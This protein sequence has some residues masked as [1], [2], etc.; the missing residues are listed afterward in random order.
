M[1]RATI[2][3]SLNFLSAS[4]SMSRPP[5]CSATSR[6]RYTLSSSLASGAQRMCVP[7]AIMIC[8]SRRSSTAHLTVRRVTLDNPASHRTS[9]ARRPR[10][11]SASLARS[12]PLPTLAR[13][14]FAH[15]GALVEGSDRARALPG[16]LGGACL[17][18]APVSRPD[19][20]LSM[21]LP[22]PHLLP[23][24]RSSP[25]SNA[26]DRPHRSTSLASSTADT[27]INRSTTTLAS[28]SSPFAI[29]SMN[30]KMVR[31]VGANRG[32]MR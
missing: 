22:S 15:Q 24:P 6:R 7:S 18:L 32:R 1:R 4:Y 17:F 13:S 16:A 5:A 12:A 31:R 25:S 23:S 19:S 30:W 28:C 3:S 10:P 29:S 21:A 9:P 14:R 2:S 26:I 11:A 20:E 8:S 27:T